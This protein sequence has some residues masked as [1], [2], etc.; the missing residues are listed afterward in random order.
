MARKKLFAAIDV[1]SHEIQMQIAELSKGELPQT[2]ETIR[3]TL[4]VGTDT[5]VSGKISQPVLEAC[6]AVLQG[7]V[8]QLRTYRIGA[9]RAVATSAFREASNR[10]FA[11]DQINRSSDLDIEVLSNAEERAYH[12]LATS[13]RMEHFNE[14]IRQG[15]LLV[16][17]GAGSIQVT[18]YDKQQFIFSQNMLLG[19]LRI[20]ELLSDL[21]RRA[22]D[23]T[24]LME[25]Y[26][27][28]DLDYY[29][30]LEPKGI[31]YKNLIVLGGE[32]AYLKKL[33]G[34]DPEALAVLSGKQFDQLYQQLL[35]SR[36]LDLSL[37]RDIPAEHA[38]LLLPAAIIMRKF[39]RFTGVNSILLP[40]ATLCDGILIDFARKKHGFVP[41]HDLNSDVISACRNIAKRFRIDLRHTDFVEK[42]ALLI[43]D[44]TSR[45][46][47]LNSR[48]RLLLQAAAILHDCGKYVNMSKHNIRSYNI[49]MATELIGLSRRERDIVAWTARFHTGKTFSDESS[50]TDLDAADQLVIAKLSALLRLADALDT[51]HQQKISEISV[52]IDES[53]L[54]LSVV[55]RQEVTLELWSLEKKG[56]LFRELF[57]CQPKIKIRRMTL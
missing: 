56:E 11:L 55:S 24:G 32:M 52:Q 22:G 23:F 47:R 35:D 14:L 53:E 3:R 15:T 45:L 49:I 2:V 29:H 9:Y 21:E 50:Y 18:V 4:P 25:E 12:I 51:A 39:T 16:D 36:P 43:F 54:I 30:L 37:N 10:A 40:T 33:A 38:T 41:E 26:I 19:S 13:A 44:E 27:S 31:L 46:H 42:Q 8:E 6:I 48:Q 5:Y 20:R 28:S 57:G 17:I 7:F 34:Y 1:G